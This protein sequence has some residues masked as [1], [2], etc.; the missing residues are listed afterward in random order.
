MSTLKPELPIL[1]DHRWD[2]GGQGSV[3]Q[4]HGASSAAGAVEDC[5][6]AESQ[7]VRVAQQTGHTE[8]ASEF[9]RQTTTQTLQEILGSKVCH[10]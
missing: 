2:T 6:A 7:H 3:G 5:Q 9:Q 8:L 1:S 10:Q 4:R